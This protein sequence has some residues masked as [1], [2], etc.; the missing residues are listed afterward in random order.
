MKTLHNFLRI[1]IIATV[2]EYPSSKT[3][4]LNNTMVRTRSERLFPI[5][6]LRMLKPR[7][8]S[9]SEQ[10]PIVLEYSWHNK[11]KRLSMNIKAKAS[12]WDS[13][14][15]SLKRSYGRDYALLNNFLQQKK[16]DTNHR[17]RQ[18][19]LEHPRCM[20]LTVIDQI[21]HDEPC[22]RKDKGYDFKEFIMS[23]IKNEYERHRIGLSV[24]KNAE[25]AMSM[26]QRFLSE[27]RNGTYRDN[28]IY[29]GDISEEIV[30]SYIEWRQRVRHNSEETIN[31][32]LTPII[33]GLEYA[34][35]LGLIPKLTFS[36]IKDL[37]IRIVPKFEDHCEKTEKYLTDEQLTSLIRYSETCSQKR[38][39]EHINIFLFSIYACGLRISDIATLRWSDVDLGNTQFRKRAVKTREPINNPLDDL[40]L[41]I[42]SEWHMRRHN[43]KYVFGLIHDDV[44]LD[45]DIERKKAI[46]NADKCIN[47]SLLKAGE[48]IGLPFSLTTHV[49]RHTFAV[50]AL[51]QGLS[52]SVVS[53]LLGHSSTAITEK[54]Y[55]KYLP[56]TL[57]QEVGKLTPSFYLCMK[58]ATSSSE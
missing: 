12:D 35:D 54:V 44:C 7:I 50:K 3:K 52:M 18:F 48:Q 19:S 38:R 11:V 28:A 13:T 33:K 27:T 29:L 56:S 15:Q 4:S 5:G 1:P 16:D 57:Q 20:N 39:K 34:S 43:S 26:F 46:S 42:L 2:L 17:M 40:V 14:Q 9:E 32:S 41:Q 21:L 6:K 23:R 31:H 8:P 49:A 22:S 47:Q 55:A 51:N 53:R 10:Y 36:N 58:N 30:Q 24:Y 25:N 45:N 37:R